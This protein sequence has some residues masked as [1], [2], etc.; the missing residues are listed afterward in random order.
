MSLKVFNTL[1]GEKEEFKPRDE[2]KVGLYVCGPTVYNFI[3][4]G[5]GRT[6][7][8]FD[9]IYRYLKYKG[10]D[11]TYVRNLT[12]VDDKIINKANEEGV[13]AKEIAERFSEAFAEDTAK[14]GLAEP[15]IIPKATEHISEMI[16][17][18]EGL[19]EKNMAYEVDGDVYYDVTGFNGYGKLA[20]RTLDDMRAGE[21]IDIDERKHFP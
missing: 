12:D 21:R 20:N 14:M 16:E 5:N 15:T 10:F 7:L 8:S 13:A 9:I 17:I 18:I 6:Y 11:V 4:I 19:I 3:H 1:T 2:G